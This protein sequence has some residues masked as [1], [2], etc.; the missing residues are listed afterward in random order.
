MLK[1]AHVPE[2]IKTAVL[3]IHGM[4]SQ[5]PLDTTR[6]VVD[7]VW[8]EGDH[9]A[10]GKRRTWNH[11]EQLSGADIDLP[12]ITTNFVPKAVN[13]RIDFHELYWANLMSETRAV[14]VLLW[15][16]ELARMGPRLKRSIRALYWCAVVFL[17]FLVLSVSL[18][19]TQAALQ[20]V[21]W[22][23][24]IAFHELPNINIP[25]IPDFK[26]LVYVA[27]VIVFV[28]SFIA[29]VASLCN[30]AFKLT[31]PSA[32]VAVLAAVLFYFLLDNEGGAEK[33]TNLLLPIVVAGAL[34]R[35]TM[36]WWGI[37][38]LVFALSLSAT[39]L[40]F[41][42]FC[43]TNCSLIKLMPSQSVDILLKIF[44][45]NTT[46]E[47]WT[48]AYHNGWIPWSITSFWSSLG[49]WYFIAIYLALYAA[50]LQPYLGD[51]A[52]YFRNSPGNV[53]VRREIRK[54]AVDTLEALHL[55]GTYDRVVIVAHSLGTVVAYDMLRAYYGRIY[56]NLPDPIMLADPSVLGK[57]FDDVD[58]GA[59]PKAKAREK[60]REIIDCMAKAANEAR[61]AQGLIASPPDPNALKVWLVT[62]FIT[63]GSPLTHAQYLMCHG[64][65]EEELEQ[66][67]VR[68]TLEQEFPTCPPLKLDG[69]GRL[70]FTL[71]GV[72]RFFHHAGLFGLTRW[73]NLFFP[74]SQLLWGDA[75]GGPVAPIFGENIAD[76]PVWTNTSKRDSFFA[77]IEYWDMK[78]GKDAPNIVALQN[79]ID[80]AD[81]G[82]ANAM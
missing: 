68:R 24:E 25:Y 74:V 33:L 61:K 58:S 34:I 43:F 18:L 69:E 62:D 70:T 53:A 26:A 31:L 3:V 40:E 48:G 19:A 32:V 9:S 56:K 59:L 28:A 44:W 51:A 13:R 21:R 7:A 67:F 64:K 4:G 8:L 65:T 50:F 46:V 41:V 45:W 6:G 11:P 20:F 76:V 54:Q 57:D 55:S 81:E 22:V 16:F 42:S 73:T 60:G 36:G 1:P 78:L 5:R 15:L 80:L 30:T 12:V 14:A 71:K 39:A 17:A 10:S 23:V 35:T 77:H 66:D 72:G 63:L 82:T 79:A 49:A 2:R 27:L 75:I 52:R 38:G 37:L 29:V 47:I